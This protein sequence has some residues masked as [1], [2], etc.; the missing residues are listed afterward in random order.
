[1]QAH[2]GGNSF[3]TRIRLAQEAF[4]ETARYDRLLAEWLERSE[5]PK[6]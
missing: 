5:P 1:M 6:E 3:A 2:E 4:A